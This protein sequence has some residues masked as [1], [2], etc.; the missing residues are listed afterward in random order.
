MRYKLTGMALCFFLALV[1]SNAG[2]QESKGGEA[3]SIKDL[4][5]TALE[6]GTSKERDEAFENLK[7]IFTF[8]PS[9][10]LALDTVLVQRGGKENILLS[11]DFLQTA[12]AKGNI[13][14][15]RRLGDRY[16]DGADFGL[17][18]RKSIGIYEEAAS[19]SDARAFTR[20][21]EIYLAGKFV[22]TDV[23]KA[24]TLL[25]QALKMGDSSAAVKL[26]DVYR[27]KID[28]QLDPAKSLEYYEIAAK[29]GDARAF[30]RMGDIYRN[31]EIVKPNREKADLQYR[32]AIELGD[33]SAQIKLAKL[34]LQGS[35]AQQKTA[36]HV[37]QPAVDRGEAEAVKLLALS[38]L[39]GEGVPRDPEKARTML[40]KRARTGDGD[41]ALTLVQI[42][43]SPDAKD[44]AANVEAAKQALKNYASI[45][46]PEATRTEH[47]MIDFAAPFDTV[48]ID[49]L[50][51][52]YNT[53]ELENRRAVMTRLRALNINYYVA[54]LQDMMK[55]SRLYDGPVSGQL[56]AA[57]IVSF[58]RMCQLQNKEK[59][60]LDGPLSYRSRVFL[61]TI[62]Q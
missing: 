51:E 7:Q 49:G 36:I 33:N 48:K 62:M 54:I 45:L 46:P 12:A 11:M 44:G 19:K 40:E 57:S 60:C 59:E 8:D 4:T 47:L 22:D 27:D 38:Y 32:K 55:R 23:P 2:A 25:E 24:V 50:V 18:P 30:V 53:L 17:D 43:L 35:A 58:A 3:Y 5:T 41:A 16:R 13:S 52:K 21:G 15:L 34:L 10:A 56:S 14:A 9:A 20:L 29:G 42:E 26:G 28:A 61:Q 37:L 1:S 39:A 6:A 31:G